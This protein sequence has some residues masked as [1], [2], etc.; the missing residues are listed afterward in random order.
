[1]AT[2]AWTFISKRGGVAACAFL[3]VAFAATSGRA[4]PSDPGPSEE[5]IPSELDLHFQDDKDDGDDPWAGGCHWHFGDKGCSAAK[6]FFSGDYCADY[7]LFEWTDDDC[8]EPGSDKTVYN[9][10]EECAE[11]DKSGTCVILKGYCGKGLDSAKCVCTDRK[12][13]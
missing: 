1:M 13:K 4:H 9:C 10:E 3:I 6:M 7:L 2:R 11:E 12:K 8:H 5:D